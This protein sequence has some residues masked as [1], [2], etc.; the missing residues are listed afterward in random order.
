MENHVL[1][2]Y[3]KERSD[4]VEIKKGTN[5]ILFKIYFITSLFTFSGGLAMTEALK[6]EL[7]DK[8][9]LISKED[10]YNYASLS[11]SLPG[12]IGVTNASFVGY[13]IKGVSGMLTAT[14]AVILPAFVFMLLATILY[15][16][17]PQGGPI[18]GA[19][20]AIRA[21]SSVFILSAA[22]SMAKLNLGPWINRV[23]AL[24]AFVVIIAGL[25]N[26][27]HVTVI[28][29]VFAVIYTVISGGEEV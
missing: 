7:V 3:I 8:H 15:H 17:L 27:L 18:Y 12:V 28:V 14:F 24:L 20:T 9:N 25:L 13:K 23:L 5:L 2:C 4:L 1:Y 6:R 19:L 22:L 16:L 26:A 11:Q 29:I 21:V 10:F